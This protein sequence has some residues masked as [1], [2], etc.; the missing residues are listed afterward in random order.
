M[1][2]SKCWGDGLYIG[3]DTVT[4]LLADTNIMVSNVTSTDNR[5]NGLSV[6]YVR[7]LRLNNCYFTNQGGGPATPSGIDIEPNSAQI[8]DNVKISD[9][10]E[11]GNLGSAITSFVN[12]TNAQVKNITIENNSA[13]T[14]GLFGLYLYSTYSGLMRDIN[15]NGYI[16]SSQTQYGAYIRNTKNVNIS[17]M[18]ISGLTS[19]IADFRIQTDSLLKIDHLSVTDTSTLTPGVYFV[20]GNFN[21]T[22]LNSNVSTVSD[23][24]LSTNSTTDYDIE[25][26]NNT[27]V[28]TSGAGIKLFKQ[29]GLKINNC[30][31]QNTGK[32]GINL[33]T[34]T[35]SVISGNILS[36]NGSATNNTY[37]A[38]A[39]NGTST[40]NTISANTSYQ[41]SLYTNKIAYNLLLASGT[42]TNLVG[43]NNFTAGVTGTINNL[44]TGNT[45]VT[46]L[47]YITASSQTYSSTIGWTGTTAPSGTTTHTYS[48]TQVGNVV[49]VRINLAYS[50]AGSALT[51]VTMV[52]PSDVPKP[53]QPTGFA[54]SN[55]VVCYGVGD[56]STGPSATG[57][58][59][60]RV[61]L[62]ANSTNTGFIAEI[63]S[64]SSNAT[65]VW[66][67]FTYL[68]N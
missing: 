54:S 53:Y 55:Y 44:G 56:F 3:A 52:L 21:C 34:L 8:V 13:S 63:L 18:K 45:I 48:W 10:S 67:S 66:V 59:G 30:T 4:L 23:A 22:I 57:A 19:P 65:N 32:E 24:V 62:A 64:A 35:N 37:S 7:G 16:T 17:N 1:K 39:I 61:W 25:F 14:N 49:T 40:N 6:T 46:P 33:T 27:L 36:D 31:I 9:C 11:T 15:I 29:D 2:L 47:T 20:G 51:A 58:S 50:V 28:S 12:Y 41:G 68:I 38:I 42:G 5:R 26:L 43:N 60:P